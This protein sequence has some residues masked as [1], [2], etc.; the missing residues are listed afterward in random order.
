MGSTWKLGGLPKPVKLKQK[1]MFKRIYRLFPY[2]MIDWSCL[3]PFAHVERAASSRHVLSE[4]E[5]VTWDLLKRVFDL[6]TVLSWHEGSTHDSEALTLAQTTVVKVVMNDCARK[7]VPHDSVKTMKMPIYL[8]Y[9]AVTVAESTLDELRVVPTGNPE[10]V[11]GMSV[12][13]H[14]VVRRAMQTWQVESHFQETNSD[15]L[16]SRRAVTDMF[17]A[18]P[19]A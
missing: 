18:G 17:L 8:Q 15:K 11:E 12:V 9:Y 5:A 4:V 14:G 19:E 1:D 16:T 13:R 10:L 3:M 2:N 7:K 6:P